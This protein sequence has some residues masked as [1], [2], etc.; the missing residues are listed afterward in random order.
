MDMNELK[1]VNVELMAASEAVF[2]TT[3]APGGYPHTRAMLNLRN[4]RQYPSL[5]D[6]F[7]EHDKEM[8]IYFTTNTSSEKITQIKAN[9]S[10][11]VYYCLPKKFHGLML[12]GKIEIVNDPEIKKRLWQDNWTMY[13]PKGYDDPD[14][15]VLRL[16]PEFARG[17]YNSARFEFKLP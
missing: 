15:T 1:R 16:K 12:G 11:S 2:L 6:F 10:V 4:R 9:Q 17:W 14:H 13:Y 3:I 5:A 8:L 7:K